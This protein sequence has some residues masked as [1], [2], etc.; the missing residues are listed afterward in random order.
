MRIFILTLDFIFGT[1]IN[2]CGFS[3]GI[4]TNGS[5]ISFIGSMILG[6]GKLTA[7]L[8]I[9]IGLLV[10]SIVSTSRR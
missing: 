7:I 10:S 3:L 8:P 4:E 6:G 2:I 5:S 1:L 9:V